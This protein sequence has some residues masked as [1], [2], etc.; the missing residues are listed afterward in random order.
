MKKHY[1]FP[2]EQ[3]FREAYLAQLGA[4]FAEFQK[5]PQSTL[6]KYGQHDA[7]A[8]M[9]LGYRPLLPSQVS[10]RRALEAQWRAEGTLDDAQVVDAT[11]PAPTSRFFQRIVQALGGVLDVVKQCLPE[12]GKPTVINT[13]RAR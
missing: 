7:I 8:I 3:V 1:G 2:L 12:H 9:R 4:S 13:F 6:K 5:D 10:L 11:L